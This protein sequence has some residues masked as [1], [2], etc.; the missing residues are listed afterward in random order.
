MILANI[1]G[2]HWNA[3]LY[4]PLYCLCLCFHLGP[5]QLRQSGSKARVDNILGQSRL[6]PA[7]P[8]MNCALVGNNL[9][10]QS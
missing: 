4:I 3:L 9:S 8:Q 1:H 6:M 5:V 2:V 7:G 10:F